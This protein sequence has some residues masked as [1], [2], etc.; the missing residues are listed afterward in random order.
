[1]TTQPDI[2]SSSELEQ[3]VHRRMLFLIAPMFMLLGVFYFWYS[4][5]SGLQRFPWTST[6][7]FASG[8][9]ALA[10]ALYSG[11]FM[12]GLQIVGVGVFAAF[13]Y[14]SAHQVGVYS[15]SLWW[16][17]LPPVFLLLAGSLRLGII[18]GA[19]LL[20]HIGVLA[21]HGP[22]SMGSV[23]LVLGD[24]HG[25]MVIAEEVSTVALLLVTGLCVHWRVRLQRALEQARLQAHAAAAAKARF[26]ANMSHEIR[27]PL[28]GVIGAVELLRSGRLS[29]AQR[30]QLIA[31]QEQ[32]AK[33]LLA[34]INDVLDW[35]KIEAGKVSLEAEPI[36]LRG[37]VFEAN[38]LFAVAAFDKGI[39]LTSSCNPDVPRRLVGDPTR[40]RQVVN[41][42]V[43]NA[44]KF[45]ERGGVHVHLTME[46]GDPNE[47]QAADG[48]RWV[49]IEVADSGIGISAE[50]Q[51]HLFGAFQQ[52]DASVT[53]RYG[54]TGLGLAICGE[55]ARL[56]GGRI[57]VSSTPG[58]GSTFTFSLPLRVLDEAAAP[59]VSA[60][61]PDV[62]L[63]CAG[64]GLTRHVRSL[65][66][67][68]GVEPALARALPSDDELQ[69]RHLVLVDLPLLGHDGRAW[70]D[71][72]AEAGARIVVMAPLSDSAIGPLPASWLLHKPVRRAA[73]AAVLQHADGREATARA[74]AAATESTRARVLLCEDNPVNQIVVQAMLNE[75]GASCR[76]AAN[77]V[78]ALQ[79]LDDEPFD[80]VLMDVQMPE[81]DG[82]AAT[83]RWRER[84]ATRGLPRLP[85]VAMTADTEVEG[86][87]ATRQAGMDDY[88]AKP[89]GMAALRDCLARHAHGRG[90][91]HRAR[92]A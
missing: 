86:G 39:E 47:P 43:S 19:A 76:V 64:A 41:N 22:Q 81:L 57:E 33:A 63:A 44:V 65:L 89:F 29:E 35:S 83:R 61:R 51:R 31:L 80:L 66:H 91:V 74:A 1:M 58:Q 24:G 49:R 75:L 53:R 56:M 8:T 67:E 14:S 34:L 10:W 16:L 4:T 70:L 52:A 87:T 79:C 78:E 90:A 37:L 2:P 12:R 23:S 25:Q 72:H 68:L 30:T 3:Q 40:I 38:E 62:L 13:T 59:A 42:L 11:D 46:G 48:L 7:M 15:S 73:L 18:T 45:T 85:V 82:L 5:A 21:V 27:T 92:H 6:T 54:G 26:M 84:E 77:G 71:R 88:L 20:V 17:V 28:N 69:G 32:S 50:Q 55:L 36:Y 9:A 60:S